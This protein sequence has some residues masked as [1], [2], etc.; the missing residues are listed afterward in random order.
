MNKGF[1][2]YFLD[3]RLK[4]DLTKEEM[5]ESLGDLSL[6][7][8]PRKR[9]SS[10]ESSCK[11]SRDLSNLRSMACQLLTGFSAIINY[12]NSSQET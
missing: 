3:K 9:E 8:N 4:R 6:L 10:E 2:F 12:V 7:L 5:E 11:V 1:H